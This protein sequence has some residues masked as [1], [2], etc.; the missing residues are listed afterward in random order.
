MKNILSENFLVDSNILVYLLDKNSPFH[1]QVNAFFKTLIHRQVS[2]YIAQQNL[3][4]LLSVLTKKHQL[5]K[6]SALQKVNLLAQEPLFHIISPLPETFSSFLKLL[7]PLPSP[8]IYD[9][10]LAAT[11][12]DNGIKAI[13][14]NN[15]KDFANMKGLKVYGLKQLA[16][17][18]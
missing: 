4:E 13:L 6:H 7:K 2:V 10:Y 3:L 1:H 14:S 18:A 12:L 17:F 11:C 5:A 15:P 16:N 9:V 8:D